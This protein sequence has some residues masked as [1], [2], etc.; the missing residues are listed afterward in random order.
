[1]FEHALVIPDASAKCAIRGMII[2]AGVLTG[3]LEYFLLSLLEILDPF[4]GFGHEHEISPIIVFSLVKI[5]L[6]HSLDLL[7]RLQ[8][9]LFAQNHR[10][11]LIGHQY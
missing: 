6:P 5:G 2:H 8:Q 1:M 9:A 11:S 3:A 7:K 10:C 4:C